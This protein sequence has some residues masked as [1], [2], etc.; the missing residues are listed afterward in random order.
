MYTPEQKLKFKK[1][2][3]WHLGEACTTLIISLYVYK[4]WHTVMIYCFFNLPP[5]QRKVLMQLAAI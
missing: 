5:I 1:A 2:S 4:L 3:I